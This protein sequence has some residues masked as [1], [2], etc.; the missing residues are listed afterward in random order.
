MKIKIKIKIKNKRGIFIINIF[1]NKLI[2]FKES[3]IKK[4]I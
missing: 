4:M 3:T 2:I 1:V